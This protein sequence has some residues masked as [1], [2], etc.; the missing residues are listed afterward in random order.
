[1]TCQ[2]FRSETMG[3]DLPYIYNIY[4][5]I[6]LMRSFTHVQN[7]ACISSHHKALYCIVAYCFVYLIF[8]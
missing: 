6:Y 4:L 8:T 5:K 3:A 7:V 1:M 2:T